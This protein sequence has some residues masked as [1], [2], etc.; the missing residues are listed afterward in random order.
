M[1]TRFVLCALLAV[2]FWSC[3][4]IPED[5]YLL[6]DD[7]T[8]TYQG[9]GHRIL[10]EEFTGVKCNNCPA[11]S[12]EAKRLQSIFGKENVIIIGIHAG[13]LATTDEKH[14]KAFNT[15]EG[16]ELFNFFQLFGVPVGF[17]NRLDYDEGTIIKA[18]GDW[19]NIIPSELE[20]L[21]VAEINLIEDSYNAG[22]RELTVNGLIE[23]LDTADGIPANTNIAIYLTEN[24]IISP[25]TMG[26]KSV[27]ENYEHNHV[28]R[29]SFTGTYG[30]SVDLSGGSANFSESI[31]LPQD[32]VKE[33]CEVVAF[34]YNSDNYEI[35]QVNALKLN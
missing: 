8:P 3:D 12:L 4:T 32:A 13:N 31:S 30:E 22:T 7:S 21:P 1:K 24:N 26:D 18:E 5:E 14:P 35:L 11:A 16:T 27:N 25:Q 19:R 9:T 15:P 34:I 20:R 17:V 23:V 29:G 6:I 28:L 33:N 2:A 10:L